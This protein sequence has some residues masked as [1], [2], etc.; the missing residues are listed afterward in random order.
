MTYKPRRINGMSP[1]QISYRRKLCDLPVTL[2]GQHAK[3]FGVMQPYATVGT[4]V[5][6]PRIQAEY[7]WETVNRVVASGGHFKT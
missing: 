3:I 4:L 5:P 1:A 6:H 7:C 2:D